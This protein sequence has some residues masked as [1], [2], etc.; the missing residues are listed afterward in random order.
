MYTI[1]GQLHRWQHGQENASYAPTDS[2]NSFPYVSQLNCTQ[3]H[4]YIPLHGPTFIGIQFWCH[5]NQPINVCACPYLPLNNKEA[6]LLHDMVDILQH[7]ASHLGTGFHFIVRKAPIRED[8]P[9][10]RFEW[11]TRSVLEHKWARSS[12]RRDIKWSSVKQKNNFMEKS[13][14][15]AWKSTQME[16]RWGMELIVCGIPACS[17]AFPQDGLNFTQVPFNNQMLFRFIFEHLG[18]TGEGWCC[19]WT[20]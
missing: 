10:E 13:L 19:G 20:V 2:V 8:K 1:N 4:T 16:C 14:E 3:A 9:E 5:N 15:Y 18:M 11:H 6:I 12:T 17:V 7:N